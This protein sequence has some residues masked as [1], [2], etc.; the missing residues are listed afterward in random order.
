MNST[1]NPENFKLTLDSENVK[2]K[3]NKT[4]D[5]LAAILIISLLCTWGYIIWDK[6]NTREL[7][8][9]KDNQLATAASEH[10]QLQKALDD[11]TMR[12]DV[13]KTSNTKK[14]STISLKDKEIEDKKIRIHNLLSKVN[15]SQ[16]ELKEAKKLIESLNSDIEGY[17]SQIALLENQKTE[18]TKA[19][20]IVTKERDNIKKDY[21]SSVELLKN[22]ENTIDIGSTLHASNFNIVGLSE[23]GNGKIKET[24]NAKKVDKLKISFDLD[25]NMITT[26]GAKILYIV[27]TDP[28]GKVINSDQLGSGKFS[29]RDG[30]AIDFTQKM[31]VNYT[32]NKRQTVSFDWKSMEVFKIGNYK[33]EVYNNGF[34]VGEG[35][36]PLKKGGIFG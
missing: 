9:Q 34:K 11:A 4:K 1:T 35:T 14:D 32:Q 2:N 18:L 15:A 22:K 24:T 8:A 7:V 27:I 5:I 30:N 3:K 21:D 29:S 33:I 25:E 20:E 28:T 16:S 6:N 23:K 31:E 12:Y 17:K 19:N 13:I 36:R 26:S 10:D